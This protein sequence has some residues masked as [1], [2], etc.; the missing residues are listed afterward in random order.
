ME[1]LPTSTLS[2]AQVPLAGALKLLNVSEPLPAVPLYVMHPLGVGATG[3]YRLK[4][5]KFVALRPGSAAIAARPAVVGA[6][7]APPP[8]EM[9]PTGL[10]S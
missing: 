3:T 7:T 5:E 6:C 9:N 4:T 10:R 8:T 2:A 1:T